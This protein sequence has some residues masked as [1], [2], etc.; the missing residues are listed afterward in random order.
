[1]SLNKQT[2]N[3]YPWV[4]HTWNPVQGRCPHQ[5]SYCYMKRGDK[6]RGEA[7]QVLKENYLNDDLGK[8]NTIFVGSST[9]MW[10][11][12]IAW[13]KRVLN[14]C[15]NFPDNTYLFQSKN[16][17]N[18]IGWTFPYNTIVGTTIESDCHIVSAFVPSPADRVVGLTYLR[19]YQHMRTMVSIEPI[20]QFNLSR[21]VYFIKLCEPEFV[22]IGADSKHNGLPEPKGWEIVTLVNELLKFTEVRTKE[23]LS[24]LMYFEESAGWKR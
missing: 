10:V 12:E 7:Q 22:S 15:R 9:D 16:P 6:W 13:I 5:C 11:G 4:T 18:M 19:K 21:F 2:G 17:L 3:M 24:R 23:N 1:M 14:H 8:G 20:M